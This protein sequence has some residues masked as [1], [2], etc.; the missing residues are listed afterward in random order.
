MY[1]IEEVYVNKVWI[2]RKDADYE[3]Y[4]YR[5]SYVGQTI[6]Q[7]KAGLT[8]LKRVPKAALGSGTFVNW[9]DFLMH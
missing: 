1:N 5:L 7:I 9:D 2:V 3:D 4:S 6:T 8:E